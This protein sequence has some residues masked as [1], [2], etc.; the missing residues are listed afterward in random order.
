MPESHNAVVFT[1]LRLS[2]WASPLF[3]VLTFSAGASGFGHPVPQSRGATPEPGPVSHETSRNPEKSAKPL[4]R[5][6]KSR[7]AMA[8]E[9]TVAVYGRDSNFL[10]ETVEEVFEEFDRIDQQMSNYKSDSELSEINR[11]AALG[12][13]LVEPNLY[14]LLQKSLRFSRD[15]GG[16]FD[17]T[18]GPLMKAWGFFRGQ[19]RLPSQAE[20][21][22]VLGHVGYRHVLLDD[23]RRTVRFDDPGIELDLGGIA[24]GYAVDR[25]VEILRENG[26]TRG[27]VSAG[28]SSIYAL[29]SPPGEKGWK[30]ALRDPFDATKAADT[31]VLKNFSV[32]TSGDYVRYFKLGGRTYSHIMDPHSGMPVEGVLS[33]TVFA[34]STIDSD[35]LS[36]L[37]VLGVEG[38]RRYLAA[39]P[40]LRALFYLPA[41]SAKEFKRVELRSREYHL[42]PDTLAEIDP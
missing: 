18:V 14:A 9:F 42:P 16:A 39:H 7:V 13:V 34:R 8:T 41:D 26:I 2:L 21:R 32:S 33:T 36:K 38:S 23:G 40:N 3:L 4:I 11:D 20:L 22:E 37:Y 10:A 1:K 24:K 35:A 27:L 19:G 17:I 28:T 5:Y 25:A 6:E 31:L 29:G 12:P 30:I 15:T